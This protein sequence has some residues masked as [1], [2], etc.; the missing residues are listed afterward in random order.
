MKK[1]SDKTKPPCSEKFTDH[2]GKIKILEDGCALRK[3]R[4]LKLEFHYQHILEKIA[5]IESNVK[6]MKVAADKNNEMT[7]QIYVW[8][9]KRGKRSK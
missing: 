2:S 4:I 7:R 9:E 8:M 1:E 5:I 3:D 6:E